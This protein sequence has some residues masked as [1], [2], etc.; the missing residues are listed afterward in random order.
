M[1]IF[2]LYLILIKDYPPRACSSITNITPL[3]PSPASP[4]MLF[5]LNER[6]LKTLKTLVFRQWMSFEARRKFTLEFVF[7]I[8]S[9]RPIIAEVVG[10]IPAKSV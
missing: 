2:C 10:L 6:S 5:N 9:L 3:I 1:G 8:V 4:Y 7:M